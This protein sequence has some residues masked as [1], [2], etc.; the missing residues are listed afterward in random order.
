M[1]RGKAHHP[2]SAP[3]DQQW[4]SAWREGLRR[5]IEIVDPVVRSV[6]RRRAFAP[7]LP[8]YRGVFDQPIDSHFRSV[9]RNARSLVVERVVTGA[10][11]HLQATRGHDVDRCKFAG[12]HRGMP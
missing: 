4:R 7:Q 6:E 2:P 12:E 5:A 8:Q 11:T 10:E 1:L 3:C 9:H